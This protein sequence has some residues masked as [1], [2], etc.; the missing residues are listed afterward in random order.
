LPRLSLSH[1][2]T[3][4]H[5]DFN[6]GD[7]YRSVVYKGTQFSLSPKQA[8]VIQ[9][10]HEAYI[11]GTNEVTWARI[12]TEIAGESSKYDRLSQLF[13]DPEGKKAYRALIAKGKR[14]DTFRLNLSFLGEDG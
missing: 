11:N 3:G 2:P 12:V 13:R 10:L 6:T 5:P 9:M 7:E 1:P 8:E 14:K 4:G